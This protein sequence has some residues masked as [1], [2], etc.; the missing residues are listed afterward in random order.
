ML[1]SFYTL[2]VSRSGN[3]DETAFC[4]C[5][6]KNRQEYETALEETKR[7]GFKVAKVYYPTDII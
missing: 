2:F 1:N 6:T 5:E 3:Y 4:V 7:R